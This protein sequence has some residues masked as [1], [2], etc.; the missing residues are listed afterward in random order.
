MPKK[1]KI[2][3]HCPK[4]HRCMKFDGETCPKGTYPDVSFLC[5][6]RKRRATNWKNR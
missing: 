6:E 3:V 4:S 2:Q 5:F 1:K